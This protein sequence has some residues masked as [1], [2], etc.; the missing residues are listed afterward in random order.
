MPEQINCFSFNLNENKLFDLKFLY[1]L[2]VIEWIKIV[3]YGFTV[4]KKIATKGGPCNILL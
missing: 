3:T 4:L 2:T 1:K